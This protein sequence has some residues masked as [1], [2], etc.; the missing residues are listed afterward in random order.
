MFQKALAATIARELRIA[1]TTVE[2]THRRLLE[3][4]RISGK[5]TRA[6][7]SPRVNA[8][9]TARTI[10]AL[11]MSEQPIEAPAALD[12]V[13]GLVAIVGDREQELVAALELTITELMDQGDLGDVVG[14][15]LTLGRPWPIAAI[16]M[17]FADGSERLVEFHH[18][19][20]R[21][22]D[23][24][25]RL[26]ELE[27]RW[28]YRPGANRWATIGLPELTRIADAMVGRTREQRP[29]LADVFASG[30][31]LPSGGTAL[32]MARASSGPPAPAK[33]APRARKP[34]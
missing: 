25:S 23:A 17:T 12:R 28:G 32:V 4:E 33:R 5:G 30:M 6:K 16:E 11:L 20:A 31:K 24:N 26:A 15:T 19:L 9:D 29:S 18:R 10:I 3:T 7:S 21:W 22:A 8:K 14:F 1:T 34:T 2:L 13:L 27:Q